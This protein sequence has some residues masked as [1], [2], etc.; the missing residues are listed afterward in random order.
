MAG[1]AWRPDLHSRARRRS[2]APV[3][4]LA[5]ALVCGS[6]RA[7]TGTS[8]QRAEVHPV[9][10][11]TDATDVRNP[12]SWLVGRANSADIEIQ[13]EDHGAGLPVVLIH[14]YPLSGRGWDK[15]VP[16]LLEAGYRVSADA[17]CEVA[18]VDWMVYS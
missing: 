2:L 4:T 14:G 15:Q 5:R 9:L 8:D 10:G 1:R 17:P 6:A 12:P 13:Y 16:A 7:H 18:P 3:P 11:W